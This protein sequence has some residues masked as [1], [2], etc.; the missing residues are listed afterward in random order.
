MWHNARPRKVGALTW[1]TL[2]NGLPVGTWLQTM[3]IQAPCKGCDQGLQESARHCL[4]ECTP[5]QKAWSAFLSVW[6]EWEVPNRLSI[7][8]PF[9]LLG[10]AMFEEKDNPP[11]LHLYHP[12]GFSYRR[13]PLNILRSF[14]LYYLWSK[15]CRR[16]FDGQCS[17]KRV[18]LQ[19]WE[20]TVEVGMATWKAIRSSS[21][22]RTMTIRIAL[23]LP[24][25]LNGFTVASLGRARLPFLGACSPPCTFSIFLMIDGAIASLPVRGSPYYYLGFPKFSKLGLLI[26]WKT[27]TSCADL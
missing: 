13:Q 2:N 14:L 20:A 19:S 8:W 24:L 10:E 26:F 12:G 6:G 16:H 1:L 9:I 3:G 11:D 4:M 27:I 15:R 22:D 17:L 7:T 5:A 18:L 25:G 21:Q 23:S